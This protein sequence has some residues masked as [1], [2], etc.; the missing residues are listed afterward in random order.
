MMS[1][2]EKRKKRKRE[3]TKHAAARLRRVQL[4]ALTLVLPL[5]GCELEEQEAASLTNWLLYSVSVLQTHTH[6]HPHTHRHTRIHKPT[7]LLLPLSSLLLPLRGGEGF[8]YPRTPLSHNL[9]SITW[10]SLESDSI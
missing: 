5:Y 4:S 8:H 1:P 2:G 3:T 10:I 6:P 7:S 9:I